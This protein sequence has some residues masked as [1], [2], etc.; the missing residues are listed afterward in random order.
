M[1]LPD[2]DLDLTELPNSEPWALPGLT[3]GL[4]RGREINVAEYSRGSAATDI[5]GG[6]TKGKNI[7]R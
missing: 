5:A 7:R 6:G 1:V 4:E 2:L 3:A